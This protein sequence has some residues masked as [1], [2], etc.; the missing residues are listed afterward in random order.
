MAESTP[1]SLWRVLYI[2]SL[3]KAHEALQIALKLLGTTILSQGVYHCLLG[4]VNV[5]PPFFQPHAQ[6]AH[7]QRI[8]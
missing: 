7:A 2:Y 1:G 3:A 8:I 4:P 6:L 5:K